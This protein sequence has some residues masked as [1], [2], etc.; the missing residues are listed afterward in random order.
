MPTARAN[1]TAAEA[2]GKIYVMGGYDDY[3]GQILD[4]VEAYNPGRDTWETKASLPLPMSWMKAV[5]LNGNIY[6]TGGLG[7]YALNTLGIY[8]PQTDSWAQKASMSTARFEHG[9]VALNGK[10]YVFGGANFDNNGYLV[11]LRSGEVY[12]PATNTWSPIAD[13]PI[14]LARMGATTD[15]R[16]IYAIG[17]TNEPSWGW[18]YGALPVV[19]RYD[20]ATDTWQDLSNTTY[21]LI[22]PK[23]ASTAVFL[24]GWGVYSMN[25]L[26]QQ[27]WWLWSS[28]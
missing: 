14:P 23:S 1:I 27:W 7:W 11:Y 21:T 20:P 26:Q 6:V 17:G 4:V 12:D 13:M 8:N 15:G 10:I 5:S 9:A 18:W 16:Y 19:L 22:T 28:D 25:G 3:S 24:P 2:R